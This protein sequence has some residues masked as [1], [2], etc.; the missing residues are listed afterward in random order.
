MKP[1]KAEFTEKNLTGNAGPVHF[2]RF[3]KKLGVD[4]ILENHLSIIRAENAEY[5]AADAVRD[6]Q[7]NKLPIFIK[8]C[9][10]I[11]FVDNYYRLKRMTLS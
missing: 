1:V 10:L 2:G 8:Q 7:E 3:M 5:S 6:F 9:Y 4:K 11:Q